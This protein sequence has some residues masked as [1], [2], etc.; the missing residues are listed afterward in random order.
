MILRTRNDGRHLPGSGGEL[1]GDKEEAGHVAAASN[2]VGVEAGLH[3]GLF[4]RRLA[5]AGE[6]RCFHALG[7]QAEDLILHQR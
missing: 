7:S 1:W 5:T 3:G 2:V 4:C 6:V